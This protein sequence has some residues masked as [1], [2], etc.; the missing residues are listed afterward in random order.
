MQ[1]Y[2]K[3]IDDQEKTPKILKTTGAP[4]PK[5]D[6]KIEFL[7][8]EDVG[9]EILMNDEEIKKVLKSGGFKPKDIYP[10]FTGT[11]KNPIPCLISSDIDADRI[12]YLL[13]TSYA[14]KLPYG[15]VDLP[16]I[17][18]QI[19]L[20][21]NNRICFTE[22]ALRPLDHFLLSRY[23][24]YQRVAYN[25]TTVALDKFLQSLIIKL[26]DDGKINLSKK[27][28]K[29]KLGKDSWY[30]FDDSYILSLIKNIIDNSHDIILKSQAQ[31]VLERKPPTLLI[32]IEF[33]GNRY[34]EEE[35]RIHKS[36]TI[37]NAKIDKWSSKYQIDSGMWLFWEPDIE[38]PIALTKTGTKSEQDEEKD[39]LKNILIL[40]SNKEIAEPIYSKE[41]SLMSSLADKRLYCLRLYAFLGNKTDD[42]KKNMKE[43]IYNEYLEEFN[44]LP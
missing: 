39:I 12:D 6:M 18:S 41:N 3:K 1:K 11:D 28:I 22:K 21:K 33:I 44:K 25:K 17:L 29:N 15:S 8:H 23:F 32:N 36:S 37:L 4:T 38:R 19:R 31:S 5:A 43:E 7:K 34:E 35:N 13:R 40:D 42:E 2:N 26:I 20:D 10:I 9:K 24:D 30:K 27:E 16:Y 14:T